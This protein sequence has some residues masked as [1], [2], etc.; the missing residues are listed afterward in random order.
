[1]Q[2]D[3]KFYPQEACNNITM[4][5]TGMV[6]SVATS[7]QKKK[8]KK[9]TTTKHSLTYTSWTTHNSLGRLNKNGR[10]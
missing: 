1:M 2:Q 8:K 9:T 5:N 7:P 4:F 10:E 3:P 6:T